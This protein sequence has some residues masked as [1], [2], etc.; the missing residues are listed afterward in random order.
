MTEQ[1]KPA[2]NERKEYSAPTYQSFLFETSDL[3][4]ESGPLASINAGLPKNKSIIEDVE[5]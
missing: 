3:M 2:D 1:L 5:W 4:Q